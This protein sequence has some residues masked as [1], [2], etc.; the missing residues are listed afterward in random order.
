VVVAVAVV[1]LV[2]SN[3]MNGMATEFISFTK[4]E[5]MLSCMS[6]SIS[7]MFI[8]DGDCM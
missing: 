6:K 3:V 5:G 1:A 7:L 8:L 2:V 4:V